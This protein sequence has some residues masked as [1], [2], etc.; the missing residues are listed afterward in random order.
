MKLPKLFLGYRD[1]MSKSEI[2]SFISKSK[3]FD[4]QKEDSKDAGT[5]LIF[6][7]SKQQTW[8]VSTN[9]RLYCILDDIRKSNLHINWSMSKAMIV[10]GDAV[11]LKVETRDKTDKTGFVSI[12]P[13]H[14]DWLYT[15]RLF[16]NTK[17][18]NSIHNLVD[19]KMFP[20]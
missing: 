7:T 3:H 20:R 16:E 11:T 12:S 1:F 19:K 5:L 18:E 2:T 9:E 13:K 4:A 14:K 6:Q 8:L 10:T 15:K 17:I